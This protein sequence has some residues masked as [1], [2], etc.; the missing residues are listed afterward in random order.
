[1][2][3]YLIIHTYTRL[4][5]TYYVSYLLCVNPGSIAE[6]YITSPPLVEPVGETV[7]KQRIPGKYNSMCKC[8]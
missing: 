1:M 4:L 7:I 5:N 3:V 6:I 8:P 2:F